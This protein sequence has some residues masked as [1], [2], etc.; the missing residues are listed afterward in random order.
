MFSLAFRSSPEKLAEAPFPTAWEEIVRSNVAHYCMLDTAEQIHLRALI[1]VFIAEK[2][3]EG[4]GGLELTDEI[5]VTISAQACLL[6]LGLPHDYYRNV[7]SI[8]VYPSTVVPPQRKLGHLKSRSLRS[9]SPIPLSDKPSNKGLSSLSGMLSSAAAATRNRAITLSIM[10]LPTNLICWTAPPMG[11]LRCETAT[12]TETGSTSARANTYASNMMPKPAGNHFSAPTDPPMKPNSFRC[13]HRAIL[14]PTPPDERNSPPTSIVSLKNTTARIRPNVLAETH[15][16]PKGNAPGAVHRKGI[17]PP[18][19]CLSRQI[20]HFLLY[21]KLQHIRIPAAHEL[22]RGVWHAT[23][24]ASPGM[25]RP[26]PSSSSAMSSPRPTPCMRHN[27]LSQS[28]VS[29]NL[30]DMQDPFLILSS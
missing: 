16:L 14:R 15:A 27:R 19:A 7:L 26:L 24:R 30:L 11:P 5:R 12:N 21:N 25:R 4:C 20:K 10:N 28:P 6:L 9:K 13:G 18:G 23:T 22:L 17:P 8:L 1:Q 3:W 2:K 29:H